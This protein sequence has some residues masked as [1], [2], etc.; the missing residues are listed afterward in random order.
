MNSQL[1]LYSM[2][3][4]FFM[5]TV[6]FVV[7]ILTVV[8]S[9][10]DSLIVGT[11]KGTSICQVK[12]SPCHD[13]IAVYHITKGDKTGTYHIVANKVVNG[14]EVD[15]GVFDFSF[16]A[17]TNTLTYTD[18]TRNASWKFKINGKT[19]DGTLYAKGQ[20]YRIIKLSKE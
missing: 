1:N 12:N 11:W 13:E 18:E 19:M 20:L 7:S 15:M 16:D 9:P 14:T 2:R 6:L 8:A 3:N 5:V 4:R 17:R 10:G